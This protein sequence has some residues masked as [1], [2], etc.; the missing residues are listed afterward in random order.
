M[1]HALPFVSCKTRCDGNAADNEA[2]VFIHLTLQ[3][4]TSGEITVP[5]MIREQ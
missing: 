5:V 1:Q 4:E 3:F 2:E